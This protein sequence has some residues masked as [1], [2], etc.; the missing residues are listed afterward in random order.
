MDHQS[1]VWANL[2]QTGSFDTL[3][4]IPLITGVNASKPKKESLSKAIVGAAPVIAKIF[5]VQ[6]S[7]ELSTPLKV[8]HHCLEDLKRK[9]VE[10][11]TG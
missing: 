3:P 9:A 1:F 8:H 7:T 5:G 6:S 11:T 4:P 2:I 10:R